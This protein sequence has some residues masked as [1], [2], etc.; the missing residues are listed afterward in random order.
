MGLS[1]FKVAPYQRFILRGWRGGKMKV[2]ELHDQ[3]EKAEEGKR[4]LVLSRVFSAVFNRKVRRNEWG[5]LRK[6][7]NLYGADTVFWALISSFHIDSSSKPLRYVASICRNT[8]KEDIE[9]M[10]NRLNNGEFNELLKYMD[11]YVKPDWESILDAS[12]E[13]TQSEIGK[14]DN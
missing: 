8:V 13:T 1:N 2:Q 7:E 12:S 9:Q 11:E 6:L 14:S 4:Y 5:M 10:D 3:L